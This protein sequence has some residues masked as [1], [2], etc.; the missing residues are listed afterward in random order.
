SFQPTIAERS[1]GALGAT[2]IDCRSA[3]RPRSWHVG[4]L[5]GRTPSS[6]IRDMSRVLEPVSGAGPEPSIGLALGGGAARGMVHVGALKA[7]ERSES[8]VA[9][10]AG[11]SYGAVIAALYALSGSALELERVIR[12]ADIGELW[13]QAF[14]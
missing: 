6:T 13:R 8:K 5:G 2:M 12:G 11:T 1:F 9:G 7:I 14:D 3:S 10:L 4:K